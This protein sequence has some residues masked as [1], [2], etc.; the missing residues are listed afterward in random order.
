MLFQFACVT[1]RQRLGLHLLIRAMKEDSLLDEEGIA[2]H[3]HNATSQK[4]EKDILKELLSLLPST[5]QVLAWA[6]SG[7]GSAILYYL[8]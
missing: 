7:R 4:F 5:D 3:I 2:Y 8:T 6:W 1:S